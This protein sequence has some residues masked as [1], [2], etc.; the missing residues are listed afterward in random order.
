[1]IIENSCSIF[2]WA[3]WKKWKL[4]WISLHRVFQ[5]PFALPVFQHQSDTKYW[6]YKEIKVVKVLQ[7]WGGT[8]QQHSGRKQTFSCP[9]C[10]LVS[11]RELGQAGQNI[12][13]YGHF[14][15]RYQEP[16]N[17]KDLLRWPNFPLSSCFCFDASQ[18]CPSASKVEQ[19]F[20]W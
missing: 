16:S 4:L 12:R 15:F 3:Q 11:L 20:S 19:V 17:N 5:C 6:F 13:N 7:M 10:W 2:H 8:L 14:I 1:M 9:M 18:P